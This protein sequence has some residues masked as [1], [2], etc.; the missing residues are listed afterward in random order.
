MVCKVWKSFL[1]L[2]ILVRICIYI[3]KYVHKPKHETKAT[4][5]KCH[6]NDYLNR[7]LINWPDSL[8][9]LPQPL[10]HG[11]TLGVSPG[12]V[13]IL[14]VAPHSAK[15]KYT[16]EINLSCVLY[17]CWMPDCFAK[18]FIFILLCIKYKN[19]IHNDHSMPCVHMISG[20]M[21]FQQQGLH[22]CCTSST[23]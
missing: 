18:Y 19:Y 14:E 5:K 20:I 15:Y 10:M 12:R 17:E 6:H 22:F 7:I 4:P 8:I 3:H 21:V 13:S 23:E 16:H 11:S 2:A 1:F 9:E